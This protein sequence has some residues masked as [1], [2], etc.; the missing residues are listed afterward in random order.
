MKTGVP[1]KKSKFTMYVTL[2]AKPAAKLHIVTFDAYKPN[3][4][5]S[6]RKVVVDGERTIKLMNAV[7]PEIMGIQ[8]YNVA[9]GEQGNN[10]DTFGITDV[11]I[12]KLD[13]ADVWM[14]SDTREFYKFATNFCENAGILST[15][16]YKS[17]NGKFIIHYLDTIVDKGQVLST[18][19]RV[20]HQSGIIEVSKGHFMNYTVAQRMIILLHEFSHKYQNPKIGRPIHDEVAA[21]I[22]AL[23]IYLGMGWARIDAREVYGQVFLTAPSQGNVERNRIIDRFIKNYDSGKLS[24]TI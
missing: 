23:Y 12:K 9:K 14:D 13:T 24:M 15:G 5:Y 1:T 21:D 2:R 22:N 10:D 3:T 7:S 4:K 19:A 6:D 8:I 20:G 18:P 11:A 16:V 17:D